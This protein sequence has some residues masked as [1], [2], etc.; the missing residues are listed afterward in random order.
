LPYLS[1]YSLA[2]ALTLQ[3]NSFHAL[4]HICKFWFKSEEVCFPLPHPRHTTRQCPARHVCLS[5]FFNS[6][7][8][9]F[10]S[11]L[12]FHMQSCADAYQA[13]ASRWHSHDN[14]PPMTV[15]AE[16]M[17]S[18]SL[19]LIQEGKKENPLIEVKQ[20]PL[21]PMRK[22]PI[23][24]KAMSSVKQGRQGKELKFKRLNVH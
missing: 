9:H 16:E 18:L 20:V 1:Q 23:G 21:K 2:R 22:V 3:F 13:I 5:L 4:D 8:F 11:S 14:P 17:I 6:N 24:L 19:R 7:S 10:I 15:Q 12:S